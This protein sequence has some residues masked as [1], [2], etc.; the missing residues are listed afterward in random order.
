MDHGELLSDIAPPLPP[1]SATGFCNIFG[2]ICICFGSTSGWFRKT[3]D[4]FQKKNRKEVISYFSS[5]KEDRF[6]SM[7][8]AKLFRLVVYLSN[9]LVN[10][11][12]WLEHTFKP[13]Q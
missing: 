10:P 8:G 12:Q 11:F 3:Q 4:N 2:K 13:K 9:E 5:W 1:G 7:T 6:G